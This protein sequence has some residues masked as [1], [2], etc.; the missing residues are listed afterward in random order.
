MGHAGAIIEGKEGTADY[1]IKLL[2]EAGAHIA[3]NPAQIPEVIEQ[4]E[5]M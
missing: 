1:K 4:M 5:V 3:R 2:R